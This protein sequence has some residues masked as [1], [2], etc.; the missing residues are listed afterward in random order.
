MRWLNRD[1]TGENGGIHDEDGNSVAR[2]FANIQG[3]PAMGQSGYSQFSESS[4]KRSWF[5]RVDSGS[6][7]V[8]LW[9]YGDGGPEVTFGEARK[10]IVEQPPKGLP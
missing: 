3:V 9:S 2:S 8:Y 10:P 1:P 7:N 6:K 5:T 4:V